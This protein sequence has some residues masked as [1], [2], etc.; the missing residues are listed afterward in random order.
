[1]RT[2][3]GQICSEA[4]HQIP[5]AFPYY[6]QDFRSLSQDPLSPYPF[7]SSP[8]SHGDPHGSRRSS[9]PVVPSQFDMQDRW[10][11]A[12]PYSSTMVHGAV[13]SNVRSPAASYSMPYNTYPH[14]NVYPPVADH[15]IQHPGPSLNQMHMAPRSTGQTR[16]EARG[17][18]P[19]SRN[20]PPVSPTEY[21]S[22][23][24]ESTPTEET[25][26]K[27]KRKRAEPWQLD[28]LNEVYARTAFPSTEERAELAKKLDMTP[29]SVQIW[30]APAPLSFSNPLT[31][32][33]TF[34]FQNKR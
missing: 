25:Q 5:S 26:V 18:S 11:G 33:F 20:T 34:R 3:R 32:N 28:V 1:M 31:L 2:N 15:R 23:S 13:P 17:P 9:T 21:E 8:V 12:S 16:G 29:R 14:S 4:S 10:Q 6:E 19:Y 24:A 30:Y 27:K 7:R 22:P